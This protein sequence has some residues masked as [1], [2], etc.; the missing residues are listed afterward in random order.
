MKI[1]ERLVNVRWCP[2][3]KG[4]AAHFRARVEN[5]PLQSL[6]DPRRSRASQCVA[7]ELSEE[8]SDA[9]TRHARF[10]NLYGVS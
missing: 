5:I 2:P 7:A 9:G 3:T 4:D 10:K 6:A 8:G 1:S